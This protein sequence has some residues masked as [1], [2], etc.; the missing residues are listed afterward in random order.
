MNVVR[1]VTHPTRHRGLQV[2][3]GEQSVTLPSAAYR[4]GGEESTQ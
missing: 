4:R 1:M 2:T 3:H